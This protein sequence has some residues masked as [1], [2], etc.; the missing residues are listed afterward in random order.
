[1]SL[2]LPVLVAI[3]NEWSPFVCEY[4]EKLGF[5][6]MATYSKEETS[7]ILQKQKEFQCV[8][9]VSDWAMSTPDS[10]TDGIIK[11]VQGKI[12]TVTIITKTSRLESGYRYMEEVFFPPNHEYLTSPFDVEEVAMRMRNMGISP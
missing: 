3:P 7:E 2:S 9:I 4:L 1:M 5:F 6:V 10:E 11:S 12:P 8:I